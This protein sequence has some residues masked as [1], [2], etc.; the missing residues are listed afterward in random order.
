MKSAHSLTGTPGPCTTGKHIRMSVQG[1]CSAC[2][3]S[4]YSSKQLPCIHARHCHALRQAGYTHA[5]ATTR[6]VALVA[7]RGVTAR[8]ARWPMKPAEHTT[9][10]AWL[11][12]PYLVAPCILLM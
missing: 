2:S 9:T 3:R 5:M 7:M 10:T 4:V 6:G 11:R 1:R 8:G 12:C